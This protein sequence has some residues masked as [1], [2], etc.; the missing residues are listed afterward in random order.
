[1][2]L[3]GPGIVVDRALHGEGDIV[4]ALSD[5]ALQRTRRYVDHRTSFI[6]ESSIPVEK[7]DIPDNARE[8]LPIAAIDTAKKEFHPRVFNILILGA[9]LGATGVVPMDRVKQ[10]I[11]KKLGYKFEKEP[12]LKDLNFRAV[13]RGADLVKKAAG[14]DM[15]MHLFSG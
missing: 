1:M 2:E 4:V 14:K 12:G 3:E 13:E 8:M 5:R 10:A 15:G 6:Y 7:R 11:E 9:L